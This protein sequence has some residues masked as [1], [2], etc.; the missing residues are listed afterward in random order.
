MHD[1]P[2]TDP[3]A[4]TAPVRRLVSLRRARSRTHAGLGARAIPPLLP[5]L[6]PLVLAAIAFG[7]FFA[8]AFPPS[9]PHGAVPAARFTDITSE[10]GLDHWPLPPRSEDAPTTLGGG[11]VSF[12]FDRD[13]HSDLFFVGGGPWP[14]EE[15]FAKRIT[16][17]SCVL[18]HN[19]G[20]GH[21]V[22]VTAA[23][24]LNVELQGMG[25]T[26]GDFDNDGLTDLFVTCVG[27][28]HLFR[29]LGGGRFE[30]VTDRAGVG[31]DEN[32][33]STGAVWIDFD[34]DGRLDLVVAHYARWPAEVDL[35]TAFRV[36]E[37][38]RSYGTPTGFVGAF[39]SVYR[40]LGDGRFSLVLDSAGLR[41]IDRQTSFPVAKTLAVVPVDANEDGRLDLLFSYLANDSALFVDEGGGHFRR[42]TAVDRR[43]EGVATGVASTGSLPFA[44]IGRDQ[45]FAAL[46]AMAGESRGRSET[47]GLL[48]PKFGGALL[49]YD[50]DGR[51][52]IFSAGGRVEP[53]TNHFES[54]RAFAA[55]PELRWNR[56]GT[57]PVAPGGEDAWSQPLWARGTA[58]ADFDGDGDL[59][60]VLAQNG[61]PPRLLR[62][63]Q[64]LGWPWLQLDLVAT[65][66]SREA[67]GTRVEVR[68]PRRTLVQTLAPAMSYLGQ[69]ERTLTFGLGDDARVRRVVVYWPDGT[70]QEFKPASINRRITLVQR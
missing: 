9:A 7:L 15:P 34:H 8:W 24:G 13:G 16:R 25:A 57:W 10:S 14:W 48:Y 49:D 32:T 22:D 23:A 27:N 40:N 65:R 1:S 55:A 35:W 17:G 20:T 12:D 43:Q 61:A 58:V 18:F 41:E 70:R 33:W 29:N 51:L 68:T 45:R 3:I 36:S 21:F 39:P 69:S 53:D 28:N 59:D 46:Q 47:F 62:N 67:A 11:V 37:V 2:R 4:V 60:V 66:G 44:A 38:G 52:D 64:R 31:G 5:V 6:L 30:D 42:A 50:L 19:D 26:A 63:D 54:G 56:G